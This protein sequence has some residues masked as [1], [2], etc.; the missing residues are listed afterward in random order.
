MKSSFLKV[1]EVAIE[2]NMKDE[3]VRNLIRKKRLV[4]YKFEGEYRIHRI[5]LDK[6]INKGKLF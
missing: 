4:A 5:D 2:L 1:K 3:Q 6:Y